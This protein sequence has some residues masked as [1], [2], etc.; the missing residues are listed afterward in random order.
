M[1]T[2]PKASTSKSPAKKAESSEVKLNLSYEEARDQLEQVVRSL[3]QQNVPLEESMQ[4]W[5]RGEEL[6][7]ICEEWL[8]GAR[9]KLADAVAAR[10]KEQG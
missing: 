6:A 7:K 5:E 2:D 4:L 8:S 9:K 10:K 1:T 3:E